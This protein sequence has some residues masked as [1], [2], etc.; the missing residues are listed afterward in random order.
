MGASHISAVART[1][2][3]NASAKCCIIIVRVVRGTADL[4]CAHLRVPVAGGVCGRN[5]AK[6]EI[7]TEPA[8]KHRDERQ[9]TTAVHHTVSHT[10][11]VAHRRTSPV[12]YQG[13]RCC[14]VHHLHALWADTMQTEATKQRNTQPPP[15]LARR[16]PQPRNGVRR[17]KTPLSQQQTFG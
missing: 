5:S 7:S 12:P 3:L 14:T 15:P 13:C 11:G 9:N 17:G 16:V 2:I 4:Q 8:H 1:C 10:T 6:R